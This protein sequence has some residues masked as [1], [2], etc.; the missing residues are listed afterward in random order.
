[1]R[2]YSLRYVKFKLYTYTNVLFLALLCFDPMSLLSKAI[3]IYNF[4]FLLLIKFQ[5]RL[6]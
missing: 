2:Q 1:M 6:I 3:H 5:M 4:Q